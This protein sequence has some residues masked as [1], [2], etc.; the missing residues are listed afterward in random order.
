VSA[1]QTLHVRLIARIG[2]LHLNVELDTGPGPLVVVG[3]NGAGK[4]SLLDLLLGA[5]APAAIERGRVTL[6]AR[7]LL[8]TESRI[9]VPLEA[10]RIGYLPQDYGL[11]P[12]LDVKANV[13]FA[14]NSAE[15]PADRRARA[16]RAREVLRELALEPLAGRRVGELSGGEKQRVALARALAVAPQALLLDEPLAALDV[17]ARREVRQFLADYLRQLALPAVVVTHDAADARALGERIVVLESGK[18]TQAGTWSELALGPASRF[19][20][21]LVTSVAS[22]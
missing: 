11:F 9:D 17:H 18:I 10:R 8:D 5:R 16:D 20:E 1:P 2:A 12:H 13:A 14:V 15:T 19:V 7:I 21:E 4:S 6:G 3:P 22:P